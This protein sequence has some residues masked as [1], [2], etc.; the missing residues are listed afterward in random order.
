[1]NVKN[2][3]IQLWIPSKFPVELNPD[4]PSSWP[5]SP[6]GLWCPRRGL[7]PSPAWSD[8]SSTC[9]TSPPGRWSHRHSS[10]TRQSSLVTD[11]K[12]LGLSRVTLF[13]IILESMLVLYYIWFFRP[14]SHEGRQTVPLST[15]WRWRS[16]RCPYQTP[17]KLKWITFNILTHVISEHK[18]YHFTDVVSLLWVLFILKDTFSCHSFIITFGNLAQSGYT[19]PTSIHEHV[20]GHP[21]AVVQDA[22]EPTSVQ[23]VHRAPRR[24]RVPRQ[25]VEEPD[26]AFHLAPIDCLE[27]HVLMWNLEIK[28]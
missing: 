6:P 3:P 14:R 5:W 15:L 19:G 4:L 22:P 21:K 1:M 24:R 26:Q 27:E 12:Q 13:L 18:G 17:E 25:P 23:T 10:H 28:K 2:W 20:I 9:E 8:C 16:C 7:P 11:T